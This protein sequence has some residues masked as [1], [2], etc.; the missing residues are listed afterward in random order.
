MNGLRIK[1]DYDKTAWWTRPFEYNIIHGIINI[2]EPSVM[3]MTSGNSGKIFRVF[4]IRFS[5]DLRFH[6]NIEI[7][8]DY[9]EN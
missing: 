9:E 2:N 8:E 7:M 4:G 6:E 5:E 1:L 3:I